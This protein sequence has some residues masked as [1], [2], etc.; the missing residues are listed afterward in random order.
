MMKTYAFVLAVALIFV[1][2]VPLFAEGTAAEGQAEAKKTEAPAGEPALL[3][4]FNA[5]APS[6]V[7]GIFGAFYPESEQVY[8]TQEMIDDTIKHGASGASMRLVYNVEKGGSY[9]GFWMKLGPN[10]TGNNFDATGYNKLTFWL[11]GDDKSGIPNKFKVELKGDPGSTIGKKYVGDISSE[12][13]KVEI[14]LTEFSNQKVDL[15]KLNEFVVVFEN[16]AVAP[17][18]KGAIYIDDVQLEK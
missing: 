10:D 16:R 18:V 15:S 14:P 12:W 7:G 17:Q 11:K 8:I 9:N 2:A 4:D 13:V 1:T 6:N 3:A 5:P